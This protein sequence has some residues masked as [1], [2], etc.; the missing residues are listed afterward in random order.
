MPGTLQTAAMQQLCKMLEQAHA[1]L[2]PDAPSLAGYQREIDYLHACAAIAPAQQLAKSIVC[3]DCLEHRIQPQHNGSGGYQAYCDE[4][5]WVVLGPQ[6]SRPWQVQPSVIA[7]WLQVG[8]ALD[9]K[10]SVQPLLEQRLWHLGRKLVNR[11]WYDF[12]FGVSLLGHEMQCAQ[13]IAQLAPAA[14]AVLLHCG[15]DAVLR[16]SALHSL[17]IVPLRAVAHIRKN[18]FML[19]NWE[20]YLNRVPTASDA[21]DITDPTETSLRLLE[22]HRVAIVEGMRIGLS[23][24]QQKFLLKLVA[25]QGDEVSKR[26]MCDALGCPDFRYAD[27]K[28]RNKQV[29]ETFV[30][31][32]G[33]GCYY[34]NNEHL[35]DTSA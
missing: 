5:G 34:L 15:E 17:N 8:L 6:Q 29:F 33:N 25:A 28:K 3:P 31:A 22:S 16:K 26:D 1:L 11:R 7:K 12:F 2:L 19:Q 21:S 20:Q 9:R 23:P 32:R 35:E 10:Q 13:S 27:I 14:N 30:V 4:C 24:L 18:A